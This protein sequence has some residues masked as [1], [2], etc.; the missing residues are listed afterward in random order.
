MHYGHAGFDR[1]HVASFRYTYRIPDAPKF[2]PFKPARVLTDGW[3]LSSITRIISG[4][5]I[6]PGYAL[7]YGTYYTGSASASIRPSVLDPNAPLESRFGLRV[8]V[9]NVPTLGN[10]GKGI[11]RGLGT[12]NWDISMYKDLNFTDCNGTSNI[13]PLFMQGTS[14]RPPRRPQLGV[15]MSFKFDY[16]LYFKE[17]PA[18]I[19]SGFFRLRETV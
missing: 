17:N 18:E 15:K 19:S 10:V 2:L 3:V 8:Y 5:P 4:A 1:S 16:L 7:N 12:N 13:N 11:I 9:A 6:A 14:A